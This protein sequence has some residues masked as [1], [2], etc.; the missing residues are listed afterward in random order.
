[1]SKGTRFRF[2]AVLAAAVAALALGS[3]LLR[4]TGPAAHAAPATAPASASAS[5]STAAASHPFT[6]RPDWPVGTRYVYA[7]DWRSE[8]RAVPPMPAQAAGQKPR[9]MEGAL[10]LSGDLV[11]RS[12]GRTSEGFLLGASLE[13][14]REVR[15]ALSSQPMPDAAILTAALTGREALL[16]MTPS[17]NLRLLRFS[18]GDPDLFKHTLQWL[19]TH[20]QPTLPSDE[21]QAR[22][23]RWDVLEDSSRGQARAVYE[24]EAEQPLTVRRLRTAYTRLHVAPQLQ[25]AVPQRLE[26]RA[27]FTFAAAGHLSGMSH[28]EALSARD[29]AGVELLNARELLKL[30]LREV[31]SFT[32]PADVG[33]ASHTE[34][35][36]PGIITT[37][38]RVQRRLL[39]QRA[40]GLTMEQLL[41]DL[42]KHGPGGQLPDHNRWLWQATGRLMLEPERCREL[43]AVFTRAGM[44]DKGRALVLDLLASAGHAQAQAVMRELLETRAA[45]EDARAYE[46]L[47]QRL[48]LVE[49]PEKESL[50]YLERK[51]ESAR[52]EKQEHLRNASA[53]ALGAAVGRLGPED[54]DGGRYNRLLLDGL[55]AAGTAEARETYLRALGNS[56]RPENAAAVLS[57]ES[58]PDARVRSGVAAALRKTDSPESTAALLRLSRAT[59]RP[60]QAEALA[61]LREH[62][63]DA[64]ALGSLRDLVLSGGLRPGTEP[65]LVSL[66]DE[67]LDGGP[68]V[69]EM[70]RF[71]AQ[72]VRDDPA[73]RTHILELLARATRPGRV[74]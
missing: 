35:R 59:E 8:E 30:T 64:T 4:G 48:G 51:Y 16:E 5:S 47:L 24:V 62:Q 58:D 40:A 57:L 71:L 70:L 10:R 31:G 1:M 56:G 17:G 66:L 36:R 19:L 3:L 49:R 52:S 18:P 65:V 21:A 43:V 14:L 27:T 41:A 23:G 74:P 38:D 32:V 68:M 9:T 34:V 26:S 72:S 13:N 15:L 33:L 29:E 55:G 54:A 12:L 60:V 37:S 69:V 63:L 50:A 25:G 67:R 53:Y 28:Q 6:L 11:L 20:V 7:L 42:L 2:A 44:G 22:A 61:A 39:E 73:L 45:H 46:L